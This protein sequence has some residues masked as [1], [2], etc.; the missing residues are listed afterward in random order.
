MQLQRMQDSLSRHGQL[1]PI[2]VTEREGR[3]EIVDGFK[4]HWAAQAIGWATLQV[5]VAV[6]DETAKWT[7]MLALNHE[8]SAITELEEALI[9]R[10]LVTTGL[11]Q[12]EIAELVGR[13]KT[14]VSRRIGLTE[15][16][17][18]EL[19]ESIRL[20]ILHPGVARRLLALPPG[21]QREMAAVAQAA[22]LGPQD[23]E[24]WVRL[25]QQASDPEVRRFIMTRPREALHHAFPE[26][27]LARPDLRLSPAGQK[28]QR[29][30]RMLT[31]MAP[32]TES[33]LRPM[34]TGP[35]LPLLCQ[36]LRGAELALERLVP[37]LG[38]VGS[39]SC[40]GASDASDAIS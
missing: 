27:A 8:R 7:M 20:G 22:K 21:N 25:W 2:I 26:R 29:Y 28:L 31:E 40:A 32:R 19:V 37:L 1:S 23:T 38:S 35:D 17:H 4:R 13:H 11:T 33:L 6:L 10:E 16:L 18:P 12:V 3:M 15:R 24:R 39:A 34:P 9:L 14:W 5:S 30:L 36:D